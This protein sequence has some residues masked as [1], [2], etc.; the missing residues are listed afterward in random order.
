[1]VKRKR[2]YYCDNLL[3]EVQTNRSTLV[4]IP[5]RRSNNDESIDDASNHN[6]TTEK[7]TIRQTPD[8]AGKD[9]KMAKKQKKRKKHEERKRQRTVLTTEHHDAQNACN[10]SSDDEH[11]KQK[12]TLVELLVCRYL[13]SHG[14]LCTLRS[15]LNESSKHD[16]Q[17]LCMLSVVGP[18]HYSSGAHSTGDALHDSD[19]L[20]WSLPRI[21]AAKTGGGGKSLK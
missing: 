3:D 19:P 7:A 1:M 6:D 9:T 12:I 5:Q 16:L 2:S 4:I 15:L 21:I 8:I 11:Q 10:N 17:Q 14:Y 18:Q 20:S 13:K